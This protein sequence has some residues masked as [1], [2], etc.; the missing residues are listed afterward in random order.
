[1][2]DPQQ[3][4][5]VLGSRIANLILEYDNEKGYEFR[6]QCE[7]SINAADAATIG[8]HIAARDFA[9]L[10]LAKEVVL[11]NVN[12]RASVGFRKIITDAFDEN[13]AHLKAAAPP[14][15]QP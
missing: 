1:M 8:A 4:G 11:R 9:R 14:T 6:V 3:G 15:S 5:G 10:G 2:S 7:V 12:A 13:A